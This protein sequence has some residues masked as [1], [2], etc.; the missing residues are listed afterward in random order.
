[1]LLEEHES[2]SIMNKINFNYYLVNIFVSLGKYFNLSHL[3]SDSP[4]LS[5]NLIKPLSVTD[6]TTI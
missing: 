4:V 1:M 6:L 2:L 5:I 3:S